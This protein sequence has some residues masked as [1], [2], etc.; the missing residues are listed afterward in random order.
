MDLSLIKQTLATFNNKGQSKEKTDYT[1]IFWKPKVGKHQVRIVPSKFNKST[2]FREIYFHYG[3]TKGPIL[4]L[5]NWGE[6]DPIAEAAQ[7]LRKSDN[8]DHWQMAKK[9][10]PKMRVFAPV[11]VR[12]EEDMGVR[13]WEFGKEIYTQLMNIAMN[14]DYGDYT[15]IQDGR[16]FIVE[17][18]D[19]T[20]AGRKVVKCILTPRVKTTPITDD[21]TALKTY[22][23]EQPD[24]FA[25]NKKHTYESLKEIFEKWA[26]PEED[27]NAPIAAASDEEETETPSRGDL[28]WEKEEKQSPYTLQ[29]KQPKADKFEDLFNEE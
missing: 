15:D 18:T 29:T 16:D 4:A 19:D 3:Y 8:P 27:D 11:I 17:G 25:I 9:I 1:K 24:I 22:L 13:L 23:E 26:N 7:K 2:P 6:A 28:P 12:G 14:E 20:V 10:T 5:T 21:A